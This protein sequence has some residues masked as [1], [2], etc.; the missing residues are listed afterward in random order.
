M[1]IKL[2]KRPPNSNRNRLTIQYKHEHAINATKHRSKC[3]G[4]FMVHSIAELS[5]DGRW[6]PCMNGRTA[7]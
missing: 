5:S 7:T 1:S 3:V 4:G 2:Q 6:K